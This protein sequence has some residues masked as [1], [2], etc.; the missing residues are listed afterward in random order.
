[1]SYNTLHDTRT[2][3]RGEKRIIKVEKSSDLEKEIVPS[4][5]RKKEEQGETLRALQEILDRKF[6][7]FR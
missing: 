5:T 2:V 7:D 4:T 6:L 1:L 3:Y